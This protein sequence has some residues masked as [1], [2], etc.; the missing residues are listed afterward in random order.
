MEVKSPIELSL[1]LPFL[2]I[3]KITHIDLKGDTDPSLQI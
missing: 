2:N 1:L 3:L